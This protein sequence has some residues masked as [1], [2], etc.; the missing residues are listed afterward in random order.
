MLSEAEISERADSLNLNLLNKNE[1]EV[2]EIIM[3]ANREE[4]KLI[5]DEYDSKYSPELLEQINN[6]FQGE[7]KNL[8]YKCFLTKAEY[9]ASE[10]EKAFKA[11]SMD[12]DTVYEIII[13]RPLPII[14]DIMTIFQAKTGQSLEKA[15][16]RNIDKQ[17]QDCLISMLKTERNDVQKPSHRECEQKADMLINT[18]P[19]NWLLNYD[20]ITNIF[21]KSSAEELVLIA[22]YYKQ[23]TKTHIQHAIEELGQ[24]QRKFLTTLVFVVSAPAEHYSYRLNQSVKGIGTNN[25]LLDRILV[26]RF[27]LDI[28]L[29]KRFYYDV[30]KVSA[31][32][33]IEDDTE[34]AYREL[35]IR[36]LNYIDTEDF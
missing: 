24:V 5:R 6:S 30:F 8:V 14:K 7:F 13:G 18:K 1:R 3:K 21:C 28:P 15:I 31:R 32:E 20:I 33:D 2:V 26:N 12:E 35:L 29:L 10:L 23:K 19:K 22:R 36:L 17:I 25:T 34:G 4:R 16:K 9:D 11:F 27:D